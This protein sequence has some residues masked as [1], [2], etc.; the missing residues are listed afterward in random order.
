MKYSFIAILLIAFLARSGAQV[1]RRE[2]THQAMTRIF[3]N[4]EQDL[5]TSLRGTMAHKI[6]MAHASPAGSLVAQLH[7]WRL[8]GRKVELL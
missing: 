6:V 4:I 8:D 1:V 5:L 7:Q 3:D 2:T